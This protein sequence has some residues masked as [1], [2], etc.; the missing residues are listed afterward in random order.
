M[1]KVLD[2]RFRHGMA[3]AVVEKYEA[4][5]ADGMR[6]RVECFVMPMEGGA[7]D[8]SVWGREIKESGQESRFLSV[9]GV[10]VPRNVVDA[11]FDALA[12]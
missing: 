12:E 3:T 7:E 9:E 11:I 5:A 6:V 2:V 1:V 4:V 10:E 8:V